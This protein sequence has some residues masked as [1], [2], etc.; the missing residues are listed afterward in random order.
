M[1]DNKGNIVIV[2]ISIISLIVISMVALYLF[3]FNSNTKPNTIDGLNLYKYEV[4][5]GE[6]KYYTSKI[7]ANKI[8]LADT[9]TYKCESENCE[10]AKSVFSLGNVYD[11]KAVIKDGNTYLIYDFAKKEKIE[12]TDK[13]TYK[14][15]DFTFDGSYLLINNNDKYYAYN[16]EEKTLS[17]EIVTDILVTN[18]DNKPYIV[19]DSNIVTLDNGKYGIVSLTSGNNLYENDYDS[20]NC[21][22][23]YCLL[24]KDNLSNLY[25]YDRNDTDAVIKDIK[26]VKFFNNKY[27]AYYQDLN[28]VI[29]DLNTKEEMKVSN[30]NNSYIIDS[31]DIKDNNISIKMYLEDDIKLKELV[32]EKGSN[33]KTINDTDKLSHVISSNLFFTSKSKANITIKSNKSYDLKMDDNGNIYDNEGTIYDSISIKD[34]IDALPEEVKG[35]VVTK[36]NAYAYLNKLSSSLKLNNKEKIF[37]INK[38]LPILINNKNSL[39]SLEVSTDNKEYDNINVLTSSD[40]FLY[41]KVIIKKTDKSSN[42]EELKIDFDRKDNNILFISSFSY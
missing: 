34:N 35:E 9:L 18:I 26:E 24:S 20:I 17:S 15:V 19:W 13:D 30:F 37:F 32:T 40:S 28:L 6:F 25:L 23:N 3:F 31:I 16:L 7:D 27:L 38:Y 4:Y 42:S 36:D 22:G 12:L 1:E 5:S 39:V 29:Y 11:T 10:F 41:V 21:Y 8:G 33:K 14:Y 2:A